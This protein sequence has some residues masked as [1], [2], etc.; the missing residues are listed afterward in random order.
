VVCAWLRDFRLHGEK[1]IAQVHRTQPG[2]YLRILALLVPREHRVEH[3]DPVTQLSDEMLEG[4]VV[5]LKRRLEK[6]ADRA[7]VVNA[8]KRPALPQPAQPAK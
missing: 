6:R 4:L 2:I 1:T 8:D 7:K 5:E 3:V